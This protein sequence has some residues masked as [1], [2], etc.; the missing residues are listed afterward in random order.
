MQQVRPWEIAVV[1]VLCAVCG[2]T[3]FEIVGAITMHGLAGWALQRGISGWA[4]QVIA[5]PLAIYR[6]PLAMMAGVGC[7]IAP[8]AAWAV[9][10]SRRGNFDPG[11]E[12]G[13]ARVAT[14]REMRAM[15]D[16]HTVTNNNPLTSTAGIVLKP[17]NAAQQKATNGLNHNITC[18][19]TS[20]TGKTAYVS[21]PMI[22]NSVGSALR[23]EADF[24]G[25]WPEKDDDEGYTYLEHPAVTHQETRMAYTCSECGE[26]K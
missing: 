12:H 26:T 3:A 19:G 11:K 1:F 17:K 15:A 21:K 25:D 20:G 22:L 24:G 14:K 16:E 23:S 4:S 6:S 13:D 9:I 7:G 5:H 18:V 2:W 10:I 8:L